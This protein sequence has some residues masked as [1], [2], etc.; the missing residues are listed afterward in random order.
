MDVIYRLV[1]GSIQK[2]F[3][4]L[5]TQFIK[6]Y[7]DTLTNIMSQGL[8]VLDLPVVKSAIS[9]AQYTA[10]AII[11]VKIAFEAVKTYILYSYGDL[12][13][14][15]GGLIIRAFY[16]VAVISSI[17]WIAKVMYDLGITFASDISAL[18]GQGSNIDIS[19]LSSYGTNEL[20]ES[21]LI[22]C[23]AV[24][25]ALVI[26]TLVFIQ[27]FIRAA[28]FA[29]LSVIGAFIALNLTSDNISLFKMWFKEMLIVCISQGLQIF[30][31]KAAFY[32]LTGATN[33]TIKIMMFLGWA[34]VTYKAPAFIK[35][36]TY[37]SGVSSAAG[38]IGTNVLIRKLIK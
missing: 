34:W 33:F 12:D 29:L 5:V 19:F 10:L 13:A 20:F 18:N 25:A 14:N 2:Y 23:I 22:L 30:L 31:I 24:I 36:F 4:D 38:S 3:A 7:T 35:Q 8:Y 17:P 21:S 9:Y 16:S 28:Y 26:L 37:S 1:S 27:T 11:S 32:S 15:P 6:F